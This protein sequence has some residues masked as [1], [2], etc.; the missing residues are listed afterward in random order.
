M[1]D[2][3]CSII[4]SGL[5]LNFKGKSAT[6]NSCCLRK[7]KFAVD[8]TT[9]FWNDQKFIPLR[10]IN[11]Q[12]VW[13][14]GCENCRSLE[15]AGHE[16]FRTG[17]NNGLTGTKLDVVGPKR[18]DLMFD[19]SCN[20]ACRT[21]N[22]Y[23]SSF[24]QKHLKEHNL[25][26]KPVATMQR[27]DDVVAALEKLD[28]SELQMLVF[29][30]GETLLGQSYWNI[31]SWLADNA[32]PEQLTLCFQT[33]GT[34]PIHPKYH[35]LISKF[36]LVKLHVSLDGVGNRFEYLRWPASWNQVVDNLM[37]IR[38]TAP[39]NVMFHIEETVSIFN[40][41]YSQELEHWAAN[42]FSANREGDVT[43]HGKHIANGMFN[44]AQ[45]T[46]EYVDAM[47]GHQHRHL[48]PKNWK[49]NPS[50]ISTMMGEIKKIDA[51]RKQSFEQ[52]FPEVAGFYARYL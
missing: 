15:T 18:I 45:C 40:L 10:N 3:Y 44:P 50:Y 37:Q 24:W 25:W 31:A 22:T 34:Q 12:N 14:Q 33:N 9:N 19:I 16:S 32:K 49:E 47:Q 6:A 17:M 52:T 48:I 51:F 23:S 39:S 1:S 27:H 41:Y 36:R 11:K 26:D 28:L 8:T 20:L 29:C 7:D 38:D 30:G 35:E 5:E 42:N 4:H 21:C 2:L 46:Q 13:A 43:N